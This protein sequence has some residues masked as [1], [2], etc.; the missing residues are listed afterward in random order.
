MRHLSAAIFL[1][2]CLCVIPSLPALAAA[3]GP[4]A[5]AVKPTPAPSGQASAAQPQAADL[6]TDAE[7]LEYLKLFGYR[8]MMEVGAERQL[9]SIIELVRQTRPD[10]A[11]GVLDLIHK[12]LRTELKV[13]AE[14]S[15][16]EMVAVFKRHMTRQDVL[17]LIGVGRDPRMQRVVR[18]QP[19]ISG[20]MEE[21]GERLAERVTAKAAPRIEERLKKLQGGQEL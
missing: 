19:A 11:P 20:D 6:P 3:P 12:E 15:V 7:V 13:A 8:E 14:Q 16:G 5:K 18:M 2:L 17:Y 21:I 1:A 9:A 10:L 4:A